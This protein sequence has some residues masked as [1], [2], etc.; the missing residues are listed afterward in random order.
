VESRYDIVAFLVDKMRS[1]TRNYTMKPR[2][3]C[4]Q[5]LAGLG[6]MA[7]IVCTSVETYAAGNTAIVVTGGYK[8]GTGEPPYDYIFQAYLEPL[9]NPPGGTNF[10]T[11]G[12]FFKITGLPGVTAASLTSEPNAPPGTIWVPIP[13]STTVEWK[14]FGTKKI[15]TDSTTGQINLGQFIVETTEN[16]TSPPFNSSNN[17]IDYF[18]SYDGGTATGTG[19]IVMVN[20]VPEPSSIIMLLVGVSAVPLFVIRQQWRQQ[21]SQAA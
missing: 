3:K 21:N 1:R 8:P 11:L 7:M 5:I 20:A 13:G 4:A 15:S 12:D 6:A 18:F 19:T 10:L 9:P 16:F 17:V 14:F 2:L